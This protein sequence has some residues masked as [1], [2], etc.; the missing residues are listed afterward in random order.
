[1]VH[2]WGE[3]ILLNPGLISIILTEDLCTV[4]MLAIK[5][6]LFILDENHVILSNLGLNTCR[7]ISLDEA[8]DLWQIFDNSILVLTLKTLVIDNCPLELLL[9]ELGVL[10]IW[11]EHL[12]VLVIEVSD[13]DTT[14]HMHSIDLGAWFLVLK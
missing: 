11:P 13:H 4:S 12:A 3:A 7:W 8:I 9:V 5:V 10:T 2:D 14:I 6:A 1:L